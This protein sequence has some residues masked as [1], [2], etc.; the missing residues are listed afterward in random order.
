MTDNEI[1]IAI[2]GE[3]EIQ[4]NHYGID[5][6]QVARNA[7]PT[8][9]ATGASIDSQYKTR[10]L[11]HQVSHELISN[12]PVYLPLGRQSHNKAM[13]LQIDV[14]HSFDHED[15]TAL[16]ATDI[17]ELVS[18]ALFERD[19]IRRLRLQGVRIESRTGVMPRFII[20][21][22]DRFE[23]LPFFRLVATYETVRNKRFK[24]LNATPKQKILNI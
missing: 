23:K 24:P 14:A 1:F 20:N 8:D 2:K 4:L 12:T 13:T 16:S 15:V 11:L 17:C 7:Q 6:F 18:D 19:A 10:I 5:N 22:K 3:I 9:Q 21:D